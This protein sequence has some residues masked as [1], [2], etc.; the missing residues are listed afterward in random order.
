MADII[1]AIET[2]YDGYRFRSRL[3]ARWAVFFNAAGIE[4]QYEPEGFDLEDVGYY[5]PDFYLPK[6]AAYVEIKPLSV[7]D[8]EEQEAK[9]KLERMFCGKDGIIVILLKGDPVDMQMQMYANDANDSGGGEGWWNTEEDAMR[10]MLSVE[11]GWSEEYGDPCI[12]YY[13]AHDHT[14]YR[15]DW[16]IAEWVFNAFACSNTFVPLSRAALKARQARF[17]HGETPEATT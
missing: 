12:M 16:Y 17:E 10:F 5:L 7:S 3:E 9:K 13:N 15:S 8:T 6:F 2:I 4:Y 11:D 14:L 1:Q